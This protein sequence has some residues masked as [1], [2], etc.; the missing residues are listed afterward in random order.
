MS[1]SRPNFEQLL[2]CVV[3]AWDADDDAG[4]GEALDVARSAVG[5]ELAD[6]A[7]DAARQHQTPTR[8]GRG[9]GRTAAKT[10]SLVASS[11]SSHDTGVVREVISMNVPLGLQRVLRRR[12]P[13]LPPRAVRVGARHA[14]AGTRGIAVQP[15]L[16]GMVLATPALVALGRAL[17]VISVLQARSRRELA[18][19]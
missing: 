8:S 19:A 2:R 1:E 11:M 18:H 10:R 17:H 16:V 7:D 9:R 6:D 5:L 15:R 4:F 14:I 3:M 12:V 13:A